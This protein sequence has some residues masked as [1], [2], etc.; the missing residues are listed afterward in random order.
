MR[1]ETFVEHLRPRAID[2]LKQ[3]SMR[4]VSRKAESAGGRAFQEAS[5]SATVV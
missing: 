2:Y 1:A 5:H 4:T 3:V